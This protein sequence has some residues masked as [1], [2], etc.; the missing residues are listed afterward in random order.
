MNVVPLRCLFLS[1]SPYMFA[2]GNRDYWPSIFSYMLEAL[3]IDPWNDRT[4]KF[5]TEIAK[6]DCPNIFRYENVN[7]HRFGGSRC[8]G[9]FNRA[10][11]EANVWRKL[12]C[13]YK[14]AALSLLL[15]W[16]YWN[17]PHT[18][19]HQT[20]V[21]LHFRTERCWDGIF[22]SS[23]IPWVYIQRHSCTMEGCSF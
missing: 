19:C 12:S 17:S 9:N 14:V 20:G 18:Y 8:E 11:K 5:N 21:C 16:L 13:V 23:I 6:S 10:R 15:S 4:D 1:S 7:K 2:D 22:I 3:N